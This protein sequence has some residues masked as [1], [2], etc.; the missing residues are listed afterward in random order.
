MLTVFDGVESF[1]VHRSELYLVGKEE[2]E[3]VAR[4]FTHFAA[5]PSPSCPAQATPA[6]P[7]S[8]P[9]NC[10]GLQGITKFIRGIAIIHASYLPVKSTILA[11]MPPIYSLFIWDAVSI[12]VK[13]YILGLY[14][15]KSSYRR[16]I[17]TSYAFKCFLYVGLNFHLGE[18]LS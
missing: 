15:C 14:A 7:P 18:R 5:T 2:L 4:M 11:T 3:S 13:C 17:K 16:L 8:E 1:A 9:V 10:L 6:P 12:H